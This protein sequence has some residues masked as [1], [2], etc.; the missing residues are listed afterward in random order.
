MNTV[1]NEERNQA[2]EGGGETLP[3]DVAQSDADTAW[4]LKIR[5]DVPDRETVDVRTARIKG[6]L[7]L[8]V[9]EGLAENNPDFRSL[10]RAAYRLLDT[11]TDVLTDAQAYEH[12]RALARVTRTFTIVYTRTRR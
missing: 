10:Y 2:P 8:L 7:H 12:C 4:A 11:N 6:A 5:L 3:F 9:R 1:E